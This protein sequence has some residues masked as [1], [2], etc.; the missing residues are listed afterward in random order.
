MLKTMPRRRF[1]SHAS[2]WSVQFNLVCVDA[3]FVASRY[4]TIIYSGSGWLFICFFNSIL[5]H[6]CIH[7]S[8]VSEQYRQECSHI[9]HIIILFFFKQMEALIWDHDRI[10]CNTLI[11]NSGYLSSS[12][13]SFKKPTAQ[14]AHY[15]VH[16]YRATRLCDLVIWFHF[17]P[18]LVLQLLSGCEICPVLFGS[19]FGSSE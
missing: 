9:T 14:H 6:N 11:L 13:S 4:V 8:Y 16:L 7:A 18:S 1:A 19:L 17:P 3:I 2:M 15:S 10:S 5:V 12:R